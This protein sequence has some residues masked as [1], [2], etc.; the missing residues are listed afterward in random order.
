MRKQSKSRPILVLFNFIYLHLPYPNN[1][2]VKKYYNLHI[3]SK[4]LTISNTSNY[5]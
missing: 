3:V 1:I 4:I 5:D 2:F